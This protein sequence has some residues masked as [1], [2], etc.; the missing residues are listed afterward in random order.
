MKT[1]D[2]CSKNHYFFGWSLKRFHFFILVLFFTCSRFMVN[3]HFLFDILYSQEMSLQS[4]NIFIK[5]CWWGS[6]PE[7]IL[8]IIRIFKGKII[9]GR[10]CI[11]PTFLLTMLLFFINKWACFLLNKYLWKLNN[12]TLQ[13]QQDK[14]LHFC[15]IWLQFRESVLP[16]A[17]RF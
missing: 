17:C 3:N 4:V 5:F 10:L 7:S 2:F 9:V 15:T 11:S 14:W 1:Y 12:Y 13:T 16:N 6:C 8:Q